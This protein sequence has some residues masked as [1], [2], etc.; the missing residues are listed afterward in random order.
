MASRSETASTE[1][2]FDVV[3]I[4]SGPAAVAAL[5][6]MA[7]GRRVA[8]V[9]G[10]VPSTERQS[11]LH[12]KIQAVSLARVEAAGVAER[13]AARGGTS[14]PLFSTAAIGGLANY[15]GQ[16]FVRW[17]AADP[18]PR[19]AFA[20][21]AEYENA[22]AHVERLFAIEGGESLDSRLF[23]EGFD[24]SRPRL[25]AGSIA[26]VGTGLGAMRLAFEATAATAR[27]RVFPRRA[28]AIARA[29]ERWAVMLDDGS[30]LW[31]ERILLGAG[32]V[33]DGQILLRSFPDLSG[34]RFTDHT[35]WLLFTVGAKQHF[36]EVRLGRHPFNALT[37][38]RDT[39]EGCT[40]FSS[41]YD[42]RGGDL[43]L[44]L[45][46]TLGRAHPWFRGWPSP[47]G[48]GMVT[49]VQVWTPE[50]YGRVEIAVSDG[51]LTFASEPPATG[52]SDLSLDDFVM[53][54]K[55]TG[56]RVLRSKLTDAA[57]GY[58]YHRL[59][60]RKQ[61]DGWTEVAEL[62][63]NRT[64]DG[65]TCIDAADLP[66]IG[67]QPHTLTVMARAFTRARSGAETLNLSNSIGAAR[68]V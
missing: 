21:F 15:W 47:P 2:T 49:P 46:S 39:S 61:D 30:R 40:L 34:L 12:P 63:R 53:R 13:V 31:A 18:W 28:H 48:T 67:C 64:G 4:G 17:G 26:E 23:G 55:R 52:R 66:H 60:L 45:A 25:L 33:G 42:M 58:H 57:A 56:V 38:R 65:V 20:S 19:D 44:L 3:V 59:Q 62:L 24:L 7:D 1:D 10:A 37:V 43:N 16:Q 5:D 22:C 27:A 11:T 54:L 50:T 36:S 8:V 51:K 14:R 35:P 6:G 29:G 9:T 41:F 68:R 32:V